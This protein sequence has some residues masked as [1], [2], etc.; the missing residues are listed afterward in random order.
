MTTINACLSTKLKVG[1]PCPIVLLF[2]HDS[3]NYF[4]NVCVFFLIDGADV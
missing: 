1:I 4:F 2:L 3:A